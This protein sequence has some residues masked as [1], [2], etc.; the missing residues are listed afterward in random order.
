VPDDAPA[1]LARLREEATA[2]ASG[3]VPSLDARQAYAAGALH[4][5]ALKAFDA[6]EAALRFHQPVQL[7]GLAE[8]FKG[9][10]TCGHGPDY[11]GDAHYEGD[12]GE[13]YCES[14]PGPVACSGCPGSPDGE[15]ADWPCDEYKAILAAL[16]R[17]GTQAPSF[18][19][20]LVPARPETGR[21]FPGPLVQSIFDEQEGFR[22]SAAP[23]GRRRLHEPCVQVVGEPHV[24]VLHAPIVGRVYF[25]CIMGVMAHRYR[26][27]PAT[28]QEKVMRDVH[29][30]HARYVW[31]LCVEQQAWWRPGRGSAPGS[32][33]RMRQLTEARA[34]E[35]WLAGGSST[36]QQQALRDFDRAMAAFFDKGNPAGH[37]KFRSKR[38]L[39]GFVIRD[40]RARRV[41]RNVGEVL[42]P[43]CGWVR[44]RWSRDLPAKPGMARVTLDRAGRWH[45]SFPAGQTP[46]GRK[47]TGAVVGVDRGVKTAMVTSDG[48][49]YRAPRISDRDA[50]HYLALQRK[51]SR[52]VKGSERR[53][54]TRAQMARIT[55]RA[56]DRRKDWAEKVSTRLVRD[57]DLI[58]F[59]KLNIRGMSAAPRPKPDPEQPGAFLPNSA[60]AK[61]GLNK[62]ILAS[63]WGTLAGRTQQK[64]E[65]SG[66]AVLYVDPRFTSQQCRACGHT[67][68]GNRDS[69][70]AFRC[71]KCG[72]EDH[73]DVNAAKNILARGLAAQAVPAHAPGHGAS[74]LRKAA[75]AAAGTARSAT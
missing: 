8:D 13:W 6:A 73:A 72:H 67:E 34:A 51:H 43:K 41:S 35:P 16:T 44:F 61:A 32:A 75:K 49:H 74:R 26:L 30:A 31:N 11:D 14:L 10:V 59:E 18:R 37:P 63:A 68:A 45:V 71:L 39:Q 65:A 27:T 40:T 17:S 54:Q 52:Q 62:G 9:N 19:A 2:I 50:G 12:G 28:D 48:Q 66:C 58:V 22:M 25:R 20:G 4:A 36:V 64:A 1:A 57:H 47:P 24:E 38:G 53:E 23:V 21:V 56:A 46:I 60:R 33:A 7:H 42:V 15:Y 55:A 69:Q 70:A 3:L 5:C 29:C